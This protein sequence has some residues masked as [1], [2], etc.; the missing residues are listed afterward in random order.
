[1]DVAQGYA[2]NVLAGSTSYNSAALIA[3][4]KADFDPAVQKSGVLDNRQAWS[5]IAQRNI[6]R[7]TFQ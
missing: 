4:V 7:S 3:N 6:C 5:L 2:R 1:M